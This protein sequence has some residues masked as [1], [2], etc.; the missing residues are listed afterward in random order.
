MHYAIRDYGTERRRA[1]RLSTIGQAPVG[2]DGRPGRSVAGDTSRYSAGL[3][4]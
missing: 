4:S 2:I 1:E 3:G